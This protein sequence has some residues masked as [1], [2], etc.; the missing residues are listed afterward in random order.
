MGEVADVSVAATR[1]RFDHGM[2]TGSP[3]RPHTINDV[4]R[5]SFTRDGES[6]PAKR[7][8]IQVTLPDALHRAVASFAQRKAFTVEQILAAAVAELLVAHDPQYARK[9]HRA[10]TFLELLLKRM[11]S[12]RSKRAAR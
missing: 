10:S 1:Y 9:R 7:V 5:C 3:R 8:T 12:G 4:G 6:L 11:T 2:V